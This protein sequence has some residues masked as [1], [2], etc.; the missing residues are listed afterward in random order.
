MEH[1]AIEHAHLAVG[2]R[3]GQLAVV[4]LLPGQQLVVLV[5]DHHIFI[6][7]R[8]LDGVQIDG[9]HPLVTADVLH[10]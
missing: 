1:A 10:A 5:A 6:F 9:E 8:Q 7:Y 4:A 2:Q 3:L